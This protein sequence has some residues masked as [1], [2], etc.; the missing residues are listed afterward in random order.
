MCERYTH[1]M[2]KQSVRLREKERLRERKA[3]LEI[4]PE[5]DGKKRM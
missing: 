2:N 5:T 1:T 4:K 3:L